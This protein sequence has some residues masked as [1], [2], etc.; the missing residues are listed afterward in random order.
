MTSLRTSLFATATIGGVIL[1]V[2]I[3]LHL[4]TLATFILFGVVLLLP[5]GVTLMLT[6][7]AEPAKSV[8]S[9]LRED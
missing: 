2:A 1:I 6:S 7:G 3:G 4:I 5:V 9:M 8:A